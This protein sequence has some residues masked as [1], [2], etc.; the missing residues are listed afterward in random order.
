MNAA[1]RA[2][3]KKRVARRLKLAKLRLKR[4]RQRAAARRL[5]YQKARLRRREKRRRQK[6]KRLAKRRVALSKLAAM[7]RAHKA[8]RKAR[9]GYRRQHAIARRTLLRKQRAAR[10]AARR[11]VAKAKGSARQQA[12]QAARALRSRQRAARAA[13]RAR[14]RAFCA[15]RVRYRRSVRY[16]VW[17]TRRVNLRRKSCKRKRRYKL[18]RRRRCKWALIRAKVLTTVP[19]RRAVMVFKKVR[20]VNK[21]VKRSWM[22]LKKTYKYKNRLVR[23]CRFYPTKKAFTTKSCKIRVTPKYVRTKVSRSKMIWGTK[24]RC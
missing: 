20:G 18:Q 13:L 5:K 24:R 9:R 3:R 16:W 7:R 11:A 1:R 4:L 14:Q 19:V 2:A 12:A 23:R 17:G 8:F 21:L 15:K 6:E 10:A 22:G